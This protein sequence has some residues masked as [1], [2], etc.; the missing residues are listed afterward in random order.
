MTVTTVL[1]EHRYTN[2]SVN[3]FDDMSI[4]LIDYR[5]LFIILRETMDRQGQWDHG[6]MW[7]VKK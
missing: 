2:I 4:G 6:V 1:E 7:Y 5:F 3:N